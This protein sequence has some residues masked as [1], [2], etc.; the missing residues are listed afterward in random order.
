MRRQARVRGDDR[1]NAYAPLSRNISRLKKGTRFLWP[2]MRV[3][4][5]IAQRYPHACAVGRY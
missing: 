1:E 5:S 4:A 3:P 2:S